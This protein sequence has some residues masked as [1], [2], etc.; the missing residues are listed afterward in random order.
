MISP[1][2]S[3]IGA[4]LNL[5][6]RGF[7]GLAARLVDDMKDLFERLSVCFRLT[8]AGQ[9][10]RHGIHHLNAAGGIAGDHAVAN[11]LQRGAQTL[12]RLEELLGPVPQY[13][14]RCPVRDGDRVQSIACEQPN[15]YPHAKGQK[16]QH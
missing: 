7:H 14:K 13:L 6:D 11:G 10:L 1:S 5:G 4:P 9:L 2:L 3:R 8:P 16:Q 15:Q 12:F